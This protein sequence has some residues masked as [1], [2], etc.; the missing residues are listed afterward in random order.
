MSARTSM[1][2]PVLNNKKVV[3]TLYDYAAS[4]QQTPSNLLQRSASIFRES[5]KP[6]LPATNNLIDKHIRLVYDADGPHYVNVSMLDTEL[7][8]RRARNRY[9]TKSFAD[10][11]LKEA[12]LCHAQAE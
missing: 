11:I 2:H 12:V 9:Y 4:S 8:V 3:L 10:L 5:V 6:P 7:H 1:H